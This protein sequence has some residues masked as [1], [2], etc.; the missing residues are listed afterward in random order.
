M[1]TIG[2]VVAF[3]VAG[4]ALF[5]IVAIAQPDDI[6]LDIYNDEEDD[7]TDEGAEWDRARDRWIDEQN[8]V[9]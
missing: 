5:L 1:T 6:E 7:G 9:R 4:L 2:E 3:L 8:G